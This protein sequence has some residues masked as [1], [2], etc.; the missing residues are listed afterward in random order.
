M[1][2]LL[3]LMAL[4]CL[5][6][7]NV[8]LGVFAM[9]FAFPLVAG[10]VLMVGLMLLPPPA[11][12]P[13]ISRMEAEREAEERERQRNPSTAWFDGRQ[14]RTRPWENLPQ[15]DRDV[16]C[17]SGRRQPSQNPGKRAALRAALLHPTRH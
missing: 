9:F 3:L 4:P 5:L 6:P 11:K 13:L 8:V 7:L 16:V 12:S 2:L 14:N 15:W 17:E 10:G 1:L